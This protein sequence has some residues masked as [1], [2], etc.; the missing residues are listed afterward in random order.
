MRR[1]A[2]SDSHYVHLG[3]KSIVFLLTK[4]ILARVHRASSLLYSYPAFSK[5]SI[6]FAILTFLCRLAVDFAALLLFEVDSEDSW[7]SSF[8][9]SVIG[10]EVEV[11]DVGVVPSSLAEFDLKNDTTP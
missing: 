5:R 8:S 1:K 10:V 2:A 7:I 6:A 4:Y 3:T 11:D 9:F